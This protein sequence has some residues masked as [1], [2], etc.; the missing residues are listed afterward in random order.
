[1]W[2]VEHPN[3]WSANHCV[4]GWVSFVSSSSFFEKKNDRK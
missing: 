1:M 2:L 4:G 3:G